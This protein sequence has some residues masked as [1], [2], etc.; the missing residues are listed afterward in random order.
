MFKNKKVISTFIIIL[1]LLC[2]LFSY[3]LLVVKDEYKVVKF[4]CAYYFLE[5]SDLLAKESNSCLF[6][7][8]KLKNGVELSCKP[9]VKS[10]DY[11]IPNDTNL[12]NEKTACAIITFDINGFEKQPNLISSNSQINDQFQVF[13]YNNGMATSL[14]SIENKIWYSKEKKSFL[15]KNIN[16]ILLLIE[17]NKYFRCGKS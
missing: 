1:S 2:I 4:A 8:L 12:I 9:L 7:K 3:L 13:S 15:K 11:S 6:S 10:C 5:K 17:M 16:S 14:N